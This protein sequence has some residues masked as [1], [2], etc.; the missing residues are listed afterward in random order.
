MLLI[1]QDSLVNTSNYLNL[2]KK[3]EYILNSDNRW[4]VGQIKD[5]RKSHER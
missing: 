5:L 2:L 1:N 3:I 4:G